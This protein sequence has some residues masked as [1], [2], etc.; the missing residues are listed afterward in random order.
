[1]IIRSQD[2]LN[3]LQMLLFYFWTHCFTLQQARLDLNRLIIIIK[4]KSE[5]VHRDHSSMHIGQGGGKWRFFV[6]YSSDTETTSF[7]RTTLTLFHY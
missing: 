1:M 4:L 5:Q 3:I 6:D 2:K 7:L